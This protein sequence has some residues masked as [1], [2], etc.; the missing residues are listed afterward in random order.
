M[1][2]SRIYPIKLDN[3]TFSQYDEALRKIDRNL[4]IVGVCTY[5]IQLN[6]SECFTK[7]YTLLIIFLRKN[8]IDLFHEEKKNFFFFFD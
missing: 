4:I 8:S 6:S 1:Q 5:K 2:M 3:N 7:D